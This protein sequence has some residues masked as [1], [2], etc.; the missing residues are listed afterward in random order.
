MSPGERGQARGSAGRSA[1]RAGAGRP[2][3]RRRPGRRPGRTLNERLVGRV[4]DDVLLGQQLDEVGHRLEDA[5]A[6]GVGRAHPVLEA[7]VDLAVEP[8]AERRVD[9][10]EK[11]SRIDEKIEERLQSGHTASFLT[12]AFFE[13][14]AGHAVAGC[15]HRHDRL[16]AAP[17]VDQRH[18]PLGAADAGVDGGEDQR[19]VGDEPVLEHLDRRRVVGQRRGADLEPLGLVPA[20]AT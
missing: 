17:A 13:P 14:F 10:Q 6:A 3:S 16:F 19:D 11:D 9:E 2:R 12:G 18:D 4:R 20:A 15:A 1:R 8:L 7:G 5:P